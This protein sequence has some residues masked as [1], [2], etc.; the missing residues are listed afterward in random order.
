MVLERW[1]TAF[2]TNE[3]CIS[4]LIAITTKYS[5]FL[6]SLYVGAVHDKCCYTQNNHLPTA[7]YQKLFCLYGIVKK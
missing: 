6:T 3:V 2:K 4:R 7:C 5:I 1:I